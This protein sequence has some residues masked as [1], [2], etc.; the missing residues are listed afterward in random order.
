MKIIF[1]YLNDLVFSE[2]HDLWKWFKLIYLTVLYYTVGEYIF[3]KRE[4]NIKKEIKEE[5]EFVFVAKKRI[6]EKLFFIT[7]NKI[8]SEYLLVCVIVL[9]IFFIICLSYLLF[10]L[11]CCTELFYV[12]LFVLVLYLLLLF[13]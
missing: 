6:F 2:G 12:K 7:K 4:F 8:I 9:F 13:I 10:Y 11:L 1:D 3:I 5:F